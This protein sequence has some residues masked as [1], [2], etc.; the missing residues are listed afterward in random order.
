MNNC[1]F[2]MLENLSINLLDIGALIVL[3]IGSLVGLALGFVRAGL[4]V[5]S[6]LGAGLTTVFGLPSVRH[7][8]REHIEDKF[9]ADLCTGATIFLLTLIAL[10]LLSSLVGGWVRDS[11]LNALDRSLGMLAGT[12]TSVFLLTSAFMIME[13][14]FP[15]D[16]RLEIVKEAKSLPIVISSARFLSEALPKNLEH[17]G[18]G[19]LERTADQAKKVLENDVYDRLVR[20]NPINSLNEDRAGYDKKERSNLERAIDLFNNRSQ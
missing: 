6:W 10:F 18:I 5:A 4:F 12:A 19:S 9:F 20:P 3:L 15:G 7:F 1:K 8:A 16:K 11:R 13:N 17:L 2:I 14:I